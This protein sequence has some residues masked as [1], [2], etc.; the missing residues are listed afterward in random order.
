MECDQILPVWPIHP[1]A[2]RHGFNNV[3][4]AEALTGT[5]YFC[6]AADALRF[7]GWVVEADEH[8]CHYGIS[9]Q[10]YSVFYRG[11]RRGAAFVETQSGRFA[12]LIGP[13]QAQDDPC[14]PS[15]E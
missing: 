9:P 11:Q 1:P 12:P 15:C 4:H 2:P 14:A 7:H 10:A 8:I 3:H 5:V 13:I 6:I